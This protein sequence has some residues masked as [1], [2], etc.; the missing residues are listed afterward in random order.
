MI[1]GSAII[2]ATAAFAGVDAAEGAVRSKEDAGTIARREREKQ[3]QALLAIQNE[4]RRQREELSGRGDDVHIDAKHVRLRRVLGINEALLSDTNKFAIVEGRHYQTIQLDKT[5]GGFSEAIISLSDSNG[6]PNRRWN[7]TTDYKQRRLR[8][9][10][11][12]RW[13]A[14]T[15]TDKDFLSEWQ[16]SC[17]FVAGILGVGAPKVRLAD[18]QEWRKGIMNGRQGLWGFQRSSRVTFNVANDQNIE[19]RLVEPTYAMRD[20]KYVVVKPG[21]ILV[22]IDFN[23]YRHLHDPLQN[24]NGEDAVQATEPPIKN[25]IDFGPDCADKLAKA[26]HDNNARER[27][28]RAPTDKMGECT[29]REEGKFKMDKINQIKAMRKVGGVDAE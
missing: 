18:A 21:L 28:C 27:K 4:L 6:L 14:D 25:E 9:M 15:A 8:S 17:N 13:L 11:L 16:A 23:R 7:R 19:V 26:I 24:G 12:R 29:K 20:G 3:Y 22:D 2:M 5:F 1:G 10:A